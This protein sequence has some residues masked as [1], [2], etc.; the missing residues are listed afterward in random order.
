MNAENRGEVKAEEKIVFQ[1]CG[2][3]STPEEKQVGKSIFNSY[4]ASC[5]NLKSEY[6]IVKP[7]IMKYTSKEFY[8]YVTNEN[9]FKNPYDTQRDSTMPY[10]GNFDH[11]LPLSSSDAANLI[12]FLK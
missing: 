8:E 9:R 12:L 3:K 7:N 4:C 6:D 1:P 11:N 10:K 2:T 5:H